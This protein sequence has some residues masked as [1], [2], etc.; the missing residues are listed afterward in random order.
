MTI[1]ARQNYPN[2]LLDLFWP[3][4][5]LCFLKSSVHVRQPLNLLL[6]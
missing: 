5:R 2:I 1:C 4:T 3:E 6:S